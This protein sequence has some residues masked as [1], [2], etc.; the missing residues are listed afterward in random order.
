[1]QYFNSSLLT[2]AR[3]SR[4][5]SQSDLSSLSKVPQTL[6]SRFEGGIIQPSEE[7]ASRLADTL[8]YPVDLFYQEDRIYGFNA[9]VFFHR[10]RADMPAKI[11]RRIHAVLNLTRMRVDR[12]LLAGDIS[13]QFELLR[14]SVEEQ[15]SPEEIARRLR[16]LL[17]IPMGPIANLTAAVE[18]A[19][20]II[21]LHKFG[22]SRTDAV[23]EWIPGHQP[24]IL[25][26]SDE[27]IGGDRYRW[28]L[29]HEL[30]HLI[31]H[32]LP[33]DSMEEEANR[34]AAEFLMPE[35]E[36]KHQLRNVRLA[37]LAA[38]KSV[39]KVS[40]AALLERAKQL[41]TISP[42]QYRYMRINLGRLG[43][44]QREPVELDVPIEKPTLISA[45]VTAHI[46]ELQFGLK[47]L[48]KLLHMREEECA[49][50]YAPDLAPTGLRLVRMA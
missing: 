8:Q 19:G 26:N 41:R 11:L 37:T 46:K 9:S 15:G 7:Q 32:R 14:M 43:Y 18:D 30:G 42:S 34:F 49:G 16:A 40:M 25:M 45:L 6:I 38:L 36:I 10:K 13:P 44:L 35:K 29:A 1:M 28:T 12:M 47:E 4:E 2:L 50:L 21:A 23:S 3:E 24:T 48:A 20:V 39:W 17:H 33:T 5:L 22:S 27:S 31:M